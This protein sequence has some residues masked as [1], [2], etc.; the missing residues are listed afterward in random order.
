MRE[1]RTD[2]GIPKE[3]CIQMKRSLALVF[4]LTSAFAV[5]AAAQ[6][7]PA[8]ASGPATAAAP[9]GP[10][11]V[12]VIEFQ[13]AVTATNEFQRDY[14]DLEKKYEP[15][16]TQLKT[17]ADEIEGLEK[18]LQAQGAGLTDA[19]RATQAKTI[20]EKKKQAQRLAEDAQNDLTG[21]MNDL[22]N[23]VAGKV[24][25]VLAAYVQQQGFSLVLDA[26]ETQQQAPMVLYHAE[27]TDVSKAVVDAYNVKSGVPAPPPQ[28]VSAPAPKPSASRPPAAH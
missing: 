24:F 19:A 22:Y 15:K 21:E 10:A 8:P 6:S 12:A 23:K 20:D 7:L 26:T 2:T 27:N 28:P 25:D 4:T 14:A 13:A 5:S 18:Q 17:L 9:A 3:F 11:K 1:A 16:R